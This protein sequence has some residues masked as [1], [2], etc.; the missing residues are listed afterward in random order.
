MDFKVWK[1]RLRGTL[2]VKS[3]LTISFLVAETC[4][5]VVF[6]TGAHASFALIIVTDK[7]A[8]NSPNAKNGPKG[9]EWPKRHK[10]AQKAQNGLNV[11]E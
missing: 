11:P 2:Q 7:M 6:F 1:V 4:F 3:G 5:F 8:Q 9:P 10:M